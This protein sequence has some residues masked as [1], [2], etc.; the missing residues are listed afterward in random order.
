MGKKWN[1]N[2]TVEFDQRKKEINGW[3]GVW[4][5]NYPKLNELGFPSRAKLWCC[6]KW[7]WLNNLN[8]MSLLKMTHQYWIQ[9]VGGSNLVM[10]EHGVWMN[11]FEADKTK[12]VWVLWSAPLILVNL[13]SK[14]GS[15]LGIWKYFP[16]A[17]VLP[18]HPTQV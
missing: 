10:G 18:T 12:H 16:C 5:L 6:K 11:S 2:L 14:Q 15:G 3:F 13:V 4:N 17:L 8:M 9:K 1:L 7:K